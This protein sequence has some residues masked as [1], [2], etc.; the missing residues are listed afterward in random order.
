MTSIHR[1]LGACALS[2]SAP[3][4][5][6]TPCPYTAAAI[7]M[8]GGYMNTATAINADGQ[9]T[10]WIATTKLSGMVG[11]LTAPDG[12]TA[13]VAFDGAQASGLSADARVVGQLAGATQ[14]FVTGPGGQGTR[15][16]DTLGGSL[17]IG[18][19]VNAAGVVVGLAT[20]IDGTA[21]GFVTGPDGQGIAALATPE[22]QSL[23]ARAINEDGRVVGQASTLEPQDHAYLTGANGQGMKDLGTLGGDQ[24]EAYALNAAAEVAGVA[25]TS[26]GKFHAFLTEANG[27]RMRD[28]APNSASSAATG[29]NAS[30]QVV[31]WT[32]DRESARRAFVTGAHGSDLQDLNAITSG[33]PAGTFL[34]QAQGIN[35][36][37]Q[38][39]VVDAQHRSWVLTPACGR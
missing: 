3:F 6:A 27:G 18:M 10:G 16:L 14:S 38:V 12:L 35:D 13:V 26:K 33:L 22:L 7:P 25:K 28:I 21:H 37:G 17:S 4:A 32:A 15:M 39:V 34:S 2:L 1:A 30:G 5:H 20:D 36:A 31:G 24:S 8:A 19:G 11:Y 9:V 23:D 29:V